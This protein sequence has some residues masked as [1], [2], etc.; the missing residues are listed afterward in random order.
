V[1]RPRF[2]FTI[3][4]LIALI[5]ICAVAF[6]LLRTPFGFLIIAFALVLPG[7]LLERARARGGKGIIGGALSTGL[8]ICA[9]TFGPIRPRPLH[10]GQEDRQ[11]FI[12]AGQQ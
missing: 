2:Q 9:C 12:K 6:A 3:R 10:D 1:N 5:A 4:Q 7:F 11:C 8:I